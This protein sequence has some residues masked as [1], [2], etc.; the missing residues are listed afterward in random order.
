MPEGHDNGA[1][2][3]PE[4]EIQRILRQLFS[5]Q[6]PEGLPDGLNI[7]PTQFAQA[8]GL[9]TDPAVLQALFA[10]L[11]QAMQNTDGGIDWSIAKKT[12]LDVA[13]KDSRK[14]S[15]EERAAVDTDFSVAALWLSEVTDI[16]EAAELPRAISRVEWV[17][18]SID[19]WTALSEPV[20]VSISDALMS[21]VAENSPEELRDALAGASKMIRGVAGTLFAMQLGTVVG[22]LAGEVFS[23]GDIGI[24]LSDRDIPTLLP[25]N[26]HAFGVGLDQ[27]LDQV[28]LYLAVRELAHARLFHHAR[29][30]RLHLF[31]A[32][33]EYAK[34]ISIDVNRIEALAADFDPSNPEEIRA[35]LT[36][37]SLIPPKTDAQIAAH[38]KLET[39]LALVEGWVDEVTR[40]ATKRLPE[41]DAIAE[42]V[43]RRRATGGPA[44]SAFS[45]L[46]GLELRP[47]RLREAATMWAAVTETAG[48]AARDQLWAHPDL[49]P[50]TNEIDSPE[51]LLTRL[52]FGT[53][54]ST[55]SEDAASDQAGAFER[56]LAALLSEDNTARPVEGE[57]GDLLSD[58]DE[59]LADAATESTPGLAAGPAA[60]DTVADD[61]QSG[62][63]PGPESGG[64]E[65]GDDLSGDNSR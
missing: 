23:G 35:A 1:D 42:M 34:G 16:A 7:D 32:I 24:A 39:M 26:V 44:E 57:F 48:V 31:T 27:P 21:A 47:R 15:A 4:E 9:P 14:P 54:E 45:T 41:S 6:M 22:K 30:L 2:E 38:E 18:D 56:A 11:Q 50:S 12:A 61:D 10:S 62:S 55:P 65:P 40:E 52:G 13:K 51:L 64:N 20:A 28:R 37:G 3:S 33:N 36:N 46:V 5:G 17:F 25:E 19:T 60:G 43:R 8:A 59:T 53:E 29:W 63:E 58:P 49:L